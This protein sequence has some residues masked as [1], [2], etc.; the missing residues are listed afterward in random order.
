MDRHAHL[1]TLVGKKK[2]NP[3]QKGLGN[4]A[5]Q[6]VSGGGRVSAHPLATPVSQD[7]SV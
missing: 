2:K 7:P 4:V 6:L 3:L 5:L 1:L